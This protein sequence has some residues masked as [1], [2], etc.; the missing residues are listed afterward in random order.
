M[1]SSD[2]AT[3]AHAQSVHL[4]GRI[5]PPHWGHMYIALPCLSMAGTSVISSGVSARISSTAPSASESTPKLGDERV[6]QDK[7]LQANLFPVWQ[8]SVYLC[9]D[10]L[11]LLPPGQRYV[12]QEVV[13]LEASCPAV[14][15]PDGNGFPIR[16]KGKGLKECPFRVPTGW[17]RVDDINIDRRTGADRYTGETEASGGLNLFEAECW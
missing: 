16:Y 5:P 9:Q 4:F 17:R 15:S 12:V 11:A 10:L 3:D 7:R 13:E 1:K 2:K 6:G 14:S 8:K